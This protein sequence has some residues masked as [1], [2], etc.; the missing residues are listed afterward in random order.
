MWCM[1]RRKVWRV[2]VSQFVKTHLT[3]QLVELERK[4][5]DNLKSGRD[6]RYEQ[7][8]MKGRKRARGM[9]W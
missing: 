9:P 3:V 2:C 6:A 1:I 4:R 7:D 5:N 8:T